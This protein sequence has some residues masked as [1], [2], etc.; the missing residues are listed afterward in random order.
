MNLYIKLVDRTDIRKISFTKAALLGML[1]SQEAIDEWKGEVVRCLVRGQGSFN[2]TG[3]Q[4]ESGSYVNAAHVV[5]FDL[6]LRDV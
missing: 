5:N 6:D 3:K 1:G 4:G 2:T